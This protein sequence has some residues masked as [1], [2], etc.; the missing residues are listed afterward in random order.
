MADPIQTLKTKLVKLKK[1]EQVALD[2]LF[3]AIE[4]SGKMQQRRNEAMLFLDKGYDGTKLIDPTG[5]KEIFGKT[6]LS[7]VDAAKQTAKYKDEAEKARKLEG[8]LKV[9]ASK[10]TRQVETAEKILETYQ[11]EKGK[12]KKVLQDGQI[13]KKEYDFRKQL[14]KTSLADLTSLSEKKLDGYEKTR[15]EKLVKLGKLIPEVEKKTILWSEAN[16]FVTRDFQGDPKELAV[17]CQKYLGKKNLKKTDA[18]KLVRKFKEDLDKTGKEHD[19]LSAELGSLSS[20]IDEIKRRQKEIAK[21]IERDRNAFLDGNITKDE[22][23]VKVALW[24]KSVA[25]D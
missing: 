5:C 24:K 22:F 17:K 25:I 20:M 14:I 18:E 3:K 16:Q 4:L 12:L 13:D 10:A 2:R 6:N 11:D 1:D 15:K 21:D 9:D 23:K 7:K 8:V 19:K